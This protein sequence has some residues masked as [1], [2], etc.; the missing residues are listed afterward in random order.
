MCLVRITGINA[1]P[2][3]NLQFS[4]TINMIKQH[5][6]SSTDSLSACPTGFDHVIA[7]MFLVSRHQASCITFSLFISA[8]CAPVRF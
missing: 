6:S 7:N 5:L 1:M 8:L 2:Q 3:Y 4:I